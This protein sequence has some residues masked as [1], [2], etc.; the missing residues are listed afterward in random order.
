MLGVIIRPGIGQVAAR[1]LP[2]YSDS[3]DATRPSSKAKTVSVPA[4]GREELAPPI[5]DNAQKSPPADAAPAL[6]E[7]PSYLYWHVSDRRG[8]LHTYEVLEVKQRTVLQIPLRNLQAGD[9]VQVH[10][11]GFTSTYSVK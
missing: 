9:T 5:S 6:P 7:P 1:P 3:V 10:Y 8:V 4:V 2:L 11:R